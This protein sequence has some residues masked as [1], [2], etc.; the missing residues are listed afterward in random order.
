M[1]I[2]TATIAVVL[3]ALSQGPGPKLQHY[4]FVAV[5]ARYLIESNGMSSVEVWTSERRLR[6][7]D[8]PFAALKTAS[9]LIPA[10]TVVLNGATLTATFWSTGVEADFVF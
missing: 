4:V 5:S 3:S 9:G 8:H 1:R 7:A 10:S 2:M 6:T